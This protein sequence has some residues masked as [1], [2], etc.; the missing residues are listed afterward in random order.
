MSKKLNKR[1]GITF[2]E[3]MIATLILAALTLPSFAYL[4]NAVKDTERVFVET[5]AI[6]HARQIMDVML[7]NIPWDNIIECPDG[8]QGYCAF[9]NFE[10][11]QN[12]NNL[13]EYVKEV[14]QKVFGDKDPDIPFDPSFK[15]IRA[16]GI[17]KTEENKGFIIRTR[18]NVYYYGQSSGFEFKLRK[19]DGVADTDFEVPSKGTLTDV[20]DPDPEGNY[21]VI[22]RI[23]VQVKY[24]L[25]KGIDPCDKKA[26]SKNIFLVA[27]K[28]RL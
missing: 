26:N 23:V 19:N 24:T 9:G 10:D 8:N 28:S 18:A 1:F 16:S 15:K 20:V 2:T 11:N 12:G 5:I 3:I 17:V 14:F 25:K 22:K 27:Y 7:N 13:R 21:N 4:S 6:N